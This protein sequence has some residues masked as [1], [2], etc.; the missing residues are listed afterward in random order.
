MVLG[1]DVG[2]HVIEATEFLQAVVDKLPAAIAVPVDLALAVDSAAAGTVEQAL[3]A[4]GDGTE[5]AGTIDDAFAAERAIFGNEIFGHG[6][7]AK[8]CVTSGMNNAPISGVY[9]C[10]KTLPTRKNQ[11]GIRLL[12]LL[13]IFFLE[14][15][16]RVG[17]FTE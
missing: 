2:V 13:A 16:F 1:G 7:T 12:S 10:M 3:G 8:N 11:E 5:T 4:K 9:H 17:K 14:Y 6:L 15:F